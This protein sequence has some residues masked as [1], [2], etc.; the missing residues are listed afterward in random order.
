MDARRQSEHAALL[1]TFQPVDLAPSASSE[2]TARDAVELLQEN[3]GPLERA[4]S[5]LQPFYDAFA[6]AAGPS[7]CPTC[8]PDALCFVVVA[9]RA[10]ELRLKRNGD[11]SGQT[12]SRQAARIR[13]AIQVPRT[14]LPTPAHPRMREAPGR[15]ARR[16]C[17]T[18]SGRHVGQRAIGP[19]R[20][21][22]IR[23]DA[24]ATASLPRSISEPAPA[25]PCRTAMGRGRVRASDLSRVRRDDARQL[26]SCAGP[27]ATRFL[28]GGTTD[29]PTLRAVGAPATSRQSAC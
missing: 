23:G 29:R 27:E 16:S 15:A 5:D 11:A 9:Q 22:C 8:P 7:R 10:T 28:T 2:A 1:K 12:P 4:E 24:A 17:R 18:R 3:Y 19:P 13:P 14:T 21:S 26:R 20:R 25:G 6:D